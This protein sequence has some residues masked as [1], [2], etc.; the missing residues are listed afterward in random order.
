MIN[1]TMVLTVKQNP[2]RG[3]RGVALY[4]LDKLHCVP[5]SCTKSNS[6]DLLHACRQGLSDL[7]HR[8]TF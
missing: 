1:Y 2:F 3:L 5:N 4:V 6:L 8:P 7:T